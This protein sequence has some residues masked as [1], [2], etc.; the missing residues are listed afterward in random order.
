MSDIRTYLKKKYRI[1]TEFTH[2]AVA[3]ELLIS[4]S[5]AEALAK[6]FCKHKTGGEFY[7]LNFDTFAGIVENGLM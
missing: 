7:L 3:E 4:E 5:E 6:P 2:D 1:Y